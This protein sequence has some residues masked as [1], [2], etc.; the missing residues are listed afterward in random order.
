MYVLVAIA[1]ITSMDQ[2][3]QFPLDHW[4]KSNIYYIVYRYVLYV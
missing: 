3:D 1:R 2:A 4:I